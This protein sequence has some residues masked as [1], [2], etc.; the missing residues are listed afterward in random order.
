MIS[1]NLQLISRHAEDPGKV[2]QWAAAAQGAVQRGPWLSSLS[3]RQAL[4]PKVRD[5]G[6]LVV[7]MDEMLRRTLGETI[8]IEMAV[9]GGLWNALV[10]SAQLECLRSHRGRCATE[11]L[12]ECAPP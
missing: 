9:A 7:G 3:R 6:R 11:F 5:I 1:G 8:H 2:H 4:D 10:D 12:D